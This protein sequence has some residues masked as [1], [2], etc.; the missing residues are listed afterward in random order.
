MADVAFPAN[1]AIA[2]TGKLRDALVNFVCAYA[3][4]IMPPD[5]VFFANQNRQSLPAFSEEFA[6]IYIVSQIRHGTSVERPIPGTG[7]A[8]DLLEI[9]SLQEY[10]IQIDLYSNGQ[11]A[12][13]RA[14]TITNVCG[15]SI[16][17]L[18]FN[19]EQ[20]GGCSLLSCDD[21]RDMTGIMDSQQYVQRFMI[22]LRCTMPEITTVELPGFDEVVMGGLPDG[23]GGM[24]PG[25]FENVE[26]HHKI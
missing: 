16:G 15:S 25:Y 10:L 11:H 14:M 20:Y 12:R 8:P 23:S 19:Q 18:F 26:V 2:T 5:N 3:L 6:S 17:P 22:Q 9:I 24:R 21:P 1:P 7:E 4:P 13:Q